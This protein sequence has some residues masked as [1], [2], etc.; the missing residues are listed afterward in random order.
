[1][2]FDSAP[3]QTCVVKTTVTNTPLHALTTLNDVTFVEAA[4]VLAQ[5][6]MTEGGTADADRLRVAFRHAVGRVPTTQGVDILRGSLDRQRR[7]YAADRAAA[8]RLLSVGESPRRTD[9]DVTEHAA[10]TAVCSLIPSAGPAA[11]QSRTGTTATG[12]SQTV[13]SRLRR[14]TWRTR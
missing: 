11:S 10:L 9:L 2:F 13:H 6:A 7:L 12:T 14:P 5:R 4:R 1:M 3:R 8:S